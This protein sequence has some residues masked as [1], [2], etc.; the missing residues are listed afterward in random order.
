MEGPTKSLQVSEETKLLV[1]RAIG[2][3]CDNFYNVAVVGAAGTGK[4]RHTS[5]VTSINIYTSL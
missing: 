2:L 4:V 1:R 3:D 5:I